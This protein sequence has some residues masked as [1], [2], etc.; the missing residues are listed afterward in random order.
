MLLILPLPGLLVSE[1][2]AMSTFSLL[3]SLDEWGSLWFSERLRIFH[4]PTGKAPWRFTTAL[5]QWAGTTSAPPWP[6]PNQSEEPESPPLFKMQESLQH[7]PIISGKASWCQVIIGDCH[8]SVFPANI[9]S[10]SWFAPHLQ[11]ISNFV[12]GWVTFYRVRLQAP[13]QP[14]GLEKGLTAGHRKGCRTKE[15]N[16]PAIHIITWMVE[17]IHTSD[18]SDVSSWNGKINKDVYE[19]F[20]MGGVVYEVV[21]WVKFST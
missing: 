19:N 16:H 12:C 21:K 17:I 1:S 9:R 3:S 6:P 5:A 7:C 8:R 2:P 13:Y 14:T 4:V 18:T 11:P 20:V 15:T 10:R